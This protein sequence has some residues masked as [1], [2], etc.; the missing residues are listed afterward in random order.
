M[1]K[2][3][4]TLIL[5]VILIPIFFLFCAI[6]VDTGIVVDKKIELKEITKEGIELGLNNKEEE[7]K[8][9]FLKNKIDVTNLKVNTENNRVEIENE[10]DVDS[11]FGSLIGIKTYKIK[12]YLKGYYQDKKIIYE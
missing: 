1:N 11:V 4:Q 2:K 5:F 9:L 7:I 6:V 8:N 12:V 10:I 3:G